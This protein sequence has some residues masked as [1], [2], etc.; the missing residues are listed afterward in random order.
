VRP[1]ST[2]LQVWQTVLAGGSAGVAARTLTAPLE[3]VKLAA[4]TRGLDLRASAREAARIVRAEVPRP[5]F[6]L[7]HCSPP[8][9]E[10]APRCVP[11]HWSVECAARWELKRRVHI[12]RVHGASSPETWSTVPASSPRVP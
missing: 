10:R 1:G 6:R 4:Q 7:A 2:R 8:C 5:S 12:G 9:S 11:T 3:R